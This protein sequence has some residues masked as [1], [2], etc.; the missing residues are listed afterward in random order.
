MAA[1][2]L[3]VSHDTAGGLPHRLRARDCAQAS[4]GIRNAG[5]V[6]PTTITNE[7]MK[8]PKPKARFQYGS[9]RLTKPQPSCCGQSPDRDS[10]LPKGAQ[11]AECPVHPQSHRSLC[12]PRS[13]IV[14][15][16][17]EST[18][19]FVWETT[20]NSTVELNTTAHA[21]EQLPPPDPPTDAVWPPVRVT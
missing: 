6:A 16:L 11:R 2:V 10:F 14:Y 3:C 4:S 5:S 12:G 9:W 15:V 18:A 7:A 21:G 13:S 19:L 8:E 17:P 20:T 1:G